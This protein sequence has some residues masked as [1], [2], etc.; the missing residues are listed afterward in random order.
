MPF[1]DGIWMMVCK[2]FNGGYSSALN[3]KYFKLKMSAV[4]ALRVMKMNTLD[5][6][7]FFSLSGWT[8]SWARAMP[9]ME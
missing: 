6:R 4:L 8:Y 2:C 7:E 5:G 9:L 3:E 1:M